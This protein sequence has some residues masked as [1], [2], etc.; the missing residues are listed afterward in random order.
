MAIATDDFKMACRFITN[1]SQ[2]LIMAIRT[3]NP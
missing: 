2:Y 1:C 3:N